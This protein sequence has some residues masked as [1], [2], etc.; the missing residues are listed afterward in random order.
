MFWPMQDI[1]GNMQRF[2]P[3]GYVNSS[4]L[5]HI[6]TNKCSLSYFYVTLK[7]RSS[8]FVWV[9]YL[10]FS[11]KYPV[12]SLLLSWHFI[13]FYQLFP[14][15]LCSRECCCSVSRSRAYFSK[16]FYMFFFKS[17][18]P[19]VMCETRSQSRAESCANRTNIPAGMQHLTS[20]HWYQIRE[21]PLAQQWKV[22][23]TDLIASKRDRSTFLQN[24]A[25]CWQA[26]QMHK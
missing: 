2:W 3:L 8:F 20:Q 4:L 21:H 26:T 24:Q 10:P 9:P 16:F 22:F 13:F 15:I 14:L 11:S 19:I 18:V 5:L 17:F 12:I 23:N 25:S 1:I 7:Y 6:W